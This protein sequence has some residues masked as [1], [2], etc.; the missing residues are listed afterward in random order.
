MEERKRGE[1]SEGK[2]M[3]KRGK[4]LNER[5]R[6]NGEQYP[7]SSNSLQLPLSV[8]LTPSIFKG[9]E[10]K[11]VVAVVVTDELPAPFAP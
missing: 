9:K 7:H 10:K 2:K 11:V 3:E 6:E 8:F 4:R 5:N 1:K